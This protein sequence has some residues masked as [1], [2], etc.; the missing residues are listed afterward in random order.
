MTKQNGLLYNS[1]YTQHPLNFNQ[2]QMML[3]KNQS[4][5][6]DFKNQENNEIK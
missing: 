1:Y 2:S 3:N 6:N 5:I 4:K